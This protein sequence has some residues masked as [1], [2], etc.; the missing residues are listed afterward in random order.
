MPRSR[1]N[2]LSRAHP[3]T[4]LRK[5]KVC[6]CQ[7]EGALLVSLRGGS[8]AAC[9][10]SPGFRTCGRRPAAP[11]P[12]QAGFWCFPGAAARPR[13]RSPQR[14]A[15]GRPRKRSPP[16]PAGIEPADRSAAH[17]AGLE[18]AAPPRLADLEPAAPGAARLAGFEPAAPASA[19]GPARRW[20]LTFAWE[21]NLP[22]PS[23]STSCKRTWR[24]LCVKLFGGQRVKSGER[25]RIH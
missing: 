17:L 13:T 10:Q 19:T 9:G 18:S 20:L 1:R 22:Y 12:P 4:P 7:G 6:C 5:T 15:P 8:S 11:L 3:T 25:E 14:R 24:S 2:S 16:P 23:V 21:P